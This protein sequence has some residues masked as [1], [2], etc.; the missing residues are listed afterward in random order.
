MKYIKDLILSFTQELV[1]IFSER[2]TLTEVDE[3][4][5]LDYSD[6]SLIDVIFSQEDDDSS[7]KEDCA[8][9]NG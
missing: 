3:D 1:D 5:D 8:K 2:K 6:A 9:D 4:D 7:G